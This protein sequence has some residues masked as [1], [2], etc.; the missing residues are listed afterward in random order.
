[1]NGIEL[2]PVDAGLAAV[3]Q[4]RVNFYVFFDWAH[5]RV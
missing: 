4:R 3:A 5:D 1:M 2:P